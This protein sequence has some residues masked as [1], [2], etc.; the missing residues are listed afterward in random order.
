VVAAEEVPEAG[1]VD[2]ALPLLS[3]TAVLT[4]LTELPAS[5]VIIL[6]YAVAPVLS[7]RAMLLHPN[8]LRG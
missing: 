4:Q 1:V 7:L 3:S 8:Q 6:E 2:P 5:M